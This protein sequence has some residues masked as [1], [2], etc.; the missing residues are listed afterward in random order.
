MV[1]GRRSG[2]GC[3]PHAPEIV[4]QPRRRV[5]APLR[6]LLVLALEDVANTKAVEADAAITDIGRG[7][8][9][10]GGVAHEVVIAG[11]GICNDG[12]RSSLGC[13]RSSAYR[14]AR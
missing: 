5:F 12:W 1:R 3:S 7:L 14:S 13:R 8:V 4:S 2:R 9:D 6:A 11:N 10:E